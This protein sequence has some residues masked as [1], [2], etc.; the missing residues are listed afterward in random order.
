MP[1]LSITGALSPLLAMDVLIYGDTQTSATMRHEVPL[2]I[3]DPF[4]YLEADGR[5][6][7]LT[8]TLEE[9]RLADRVSDLECLLIDALGWDELR[10]EERS[11]AEIERELCL[12]AA[13]SLRIDEAVIPPEFPV[14][15]A[16]YLRGAGV[17]L[18]PDEAL[19]DER[20]RHKTAAEMA[21][22]RRAAGV[23]VEAMGVAATMLREASIEGDGL[24][25]AGE[26]LTAERVRSSIRE[27]CARAGAP[28]PAEIMVVASGPT[29]PIGHQEGHGPLPAHTP[30]EVDLWP[31]DEASGCW[32]DMTRTFV[33][34][35]ISDQV[36]E[37]HAIALEAHERACDG[38]VPGVTGTELH[39]LAC[40]VFER[41]GYPTQRTKKHG[42]PLREGFYYALGHG[43]GLQV[44]E[45][46]LLGRGER[47]PLIEGD[48]IAIEPGI[49]HPGVG[50]T[51][52]EDLVLVSSDGLERLTGAF[53]YDLIP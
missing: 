40:D 44:H 24:Y 29:G 45:P 6:V 3:G 51:R 5:R 12:R 28:A 7:V 11:R 34:G 2:S 4:L 49:F 37:I 20:R 14:Y 50:G 36:A 32:A 19:F 22:I 23:A 41:A 25:L 38:A 30:I 1:V 43:V 9:S 52:V 21:G 17:R 39:G 13:L 15:L 53:P 46:P 10:D 33:R 31:Q 47:E 26:L 42:Q 48:V 27:T 16:D 18:N 8:S 35:T